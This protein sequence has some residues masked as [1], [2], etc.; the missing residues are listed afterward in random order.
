MNIYL[1]FAI[2]VGITAY[3]WVWRRAAIYIFL[4][5]TDCQNRW[6]NI[7]FTSIAATFTVPFVAVYLLGKVSYSLIFKLINYIPDMMHIRNRIVNNIFGV[8]EEYRK[9]E[10]KSKKKAR[11]YYEGKTYY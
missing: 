2:G 3:L 9:I 6:G 11:D 7:I 1:W 5:E 4:H 8:E 10:E